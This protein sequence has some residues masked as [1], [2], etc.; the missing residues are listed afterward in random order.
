MDS[1]ECPRWGTRGRI[2]QLALYSAMTISADTAR[3]I[4]D[5]MREI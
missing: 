2:R 5:G 4:V 1:S 3:H